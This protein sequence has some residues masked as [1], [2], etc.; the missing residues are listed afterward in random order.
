MDKIHI[1]IE[2]AKKIK[3]DALKA[4]EQLDNGVEA[5]NAAALLKA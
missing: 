3:M 5:K 4:M 2:Q 1:A